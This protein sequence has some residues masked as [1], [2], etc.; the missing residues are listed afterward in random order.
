MAAKPPVGADPAQI[1]D[2]AGFARALTELRLAAD[3][4]VREVA[5]RADQRHSTLGGWFSGQHLPQ[6]SQGEVLNDVL[7]I[8]G[9]GEQD[10]PAWADALER[11]RRAVP[12]AAAATIEPYRGL[13]P[14]ETSDAEWFYGRDALTRIVLDRLD[15]A[16]SS[17]EPAIVA[18]VAASGAG[19][20]SLLRAGVIPAVHTYGLPSNSGPWHTVLLTPGRD[21]L[22]A[23]AHREPSTD[24][25]AATLVVI[26]QF[27]ELFAG[28]VDEG[29]R[30]QF[31]EALCS[32]D[33]PDLT[34]ARTVVA[35]GLRADFYA[36]AASDLTLAAVLQDAQVVVP[37]MRA[38]ELRDAI[39]EPARHAG[40]DVTP[41]LVEL[42]LR[43]LG[44]R[45]GQPRET[46]TLPLLSHALQATWQ[47]AGGHQLTVAHY[48]AT[49]GIAGAVQ[50]SAEAAYSGLEPAD[51][52]LARR[53]F[54]SLVHVDTDGHA[55]TGRRLDIDDLPKAG[56]GASL[57]RVLHQFVGQRLLVADE[58]TVHISHDALLTAWGRLRDW[59]DNDRAELRAQRRLEDA[60]RIW[61]ENDREPSLLLR[62]TRLQ[63]ARDVLDRV[64]MPD[65]DRAYVEASVKAA[66][67]EQAAT[68]RR[69]RRARQILAAFAVV[70]VVAIVSL[71][72]AVH[73]TSSADNERRA[74]VAVG[75][76]A[77]S[78][79]VAIEAR[80]MQSQ[81]PALA[82]QLA[83]VAW[84]I[85][86]TVEARSA[87]LDR[88][89]A[90]LVTRILGAAGPTAI[91]L[92]ADGTTLAVGHGDDGS[93]HIYRL[94]NV[95][96]PRQVA[97][98]SGPKG[99]QV[100]A[101]TFTGHELATGG[102]TGDVRLFDLTDP[103]HPKATAT[104]G[105]AF[106]GGVQSIAVSGDGHTLAAV[107]I[108]P[109]PVRLWD[110]TDPAA[111]TALP[112][113]TGVPDSATEQ[114]VTFDSTGHTLVAVGT[115][116]EG[117]VWN[118]AAPGG[119][120]RTFSVGTTGSTLDTVIYDPHGD[121][122]VGNR[123]GQ[124]DFLDPTTLKVV[125]ELR[126]AATTRI[127][128][129]AFSP[130]GRQLVAGDSSNVLTRWDTSTWAE[131]DTVNSPG[132]VTGVA[133]TPDGHTLIS[134]AA[135]GTVRLSSAAV[136][137]SPDAGSTVWAAEDSTSGN[138]LGFADSNAARLWDIT[139]PTDPKPTGPAITSG[140]TADGSLAI[141]GD[142]SLT[143]VG[144]ADGHVQLW[145]TSTPAH[146]TTVGSPIAVTTS[147]IESMAFSPDGKILAV[148]ADDNRLHLYDVTDPAHPTAVA[149]ETT[150]GL[151]YEVV[152]SPNG[153]LVA[154]GS[155]D[156]HAYLWDI[157]DPA[158]PKQIAKLG[159][160]ASYVIAVAFNP[161][162]TLFTATGADH[163]V[164]LWRVS[165]TT[166]TAVGP[167]LTGPTG[168]DMDESF[169]SNGGLLA[170]ASNDRY[171]WIWNV[172]NPAVPRLYAKLAA[173]N[174]E[175]N[176]VKFTKAG[177]LVGGGSG[178]TLPIWQTNPSLV[179]AQVCADAGDPIT[180]AEWQLY[181]PGANYAP[182][183]SPGK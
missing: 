80:D 151:V 66:S 25:A 55:V 112:A 130:D 139:D 166:L 153:E 61:V 22:D 50:Q 65:A 103:A 165:G 175:V 182:P 45:T 109:K 4:S 91:A 143:A 67:A 90:P 33:D 79:Q 73:A 134:S 57:E 76:A 5:K 163:T 108:G 161:A 42:L 53:V 126:V 20:S 26:D 43:D 24:D 138:L 183:C 136:P 135:D 36:A 105:P 38:D 68:R 47:Q 122:V 171:V 162:G 102:T 147:L 85:S 168:Y 137:I 29:V 41:D 48:L 148:S 34:G 159:G 115:N 30:S 3:L 88:S 179:A 146:A 114:G 140:G 27:E 133:Y 13:Q 46:G 72:F 60:R 154:A 17:E 1:T 150:G 32:A 121:L 131:I 83:V 97:V 149:T 157:H 123:H 54:T 164:R 87:L 59:V 180:T 127:D 70:A 145:D 19:K 63:A 101:M 12:P 69:L 14:F 21:P 77:L 160:Y 31:I 129:L 8:C 176:A 177:E 132:P 118:L 9:A 6:R 74:A 116:G 169:S 93:V 113:P 181:V 81:D 71:G 142:G 18:V 106:A 120:P 174:G 7:R 51:R 35:I 98:I 75:N 10:L 23:W 156:N 170:V 96:S 110:I 173:V 95:T 15:D 152:F 100:F 58:N 117:Y 178:V 124:V 28:D 56:P 86:P 128:V 62:G 158:H 78:R 52:D 155:A 92:S 167:V 119:K 37:P 107:S 172:H 99:S 89:A 49:G 64:D 141:R 94:T 144:T 39:V 40:T 111:P 84:R 44:P 11:A 16:L 2:R 125:R 82:E 104:L